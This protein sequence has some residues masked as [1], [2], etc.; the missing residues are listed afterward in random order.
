MHSVVSKHAVG[1]RNE[2]QKYRPAPL[3]V[4]QKRDLS[5]KHLKAPLITLNSSTRVKA[6]TFIEFE[7]QEQ[8]VGKIETNEYGLSVRATPHTPPWESLMHRA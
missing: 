5:K 1:P 4:Q 6:M 3:I 2:V 8:S 7:M